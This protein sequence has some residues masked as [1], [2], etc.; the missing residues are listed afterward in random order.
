[1]RRDFRKSARRRARLAGALSGLLAVSCLSLGAPTARLPLEPASSEKIIVASFDFPESALLAELYAGILEADDYPVTRLINLGSRETV[2][3]ALLQG[4]VDLVP[5][6]LGT[7]LAFSSLGRSNPSSNTRDMT[8]KLTAVLQ[9]RGVSVA[10]PAEAQNRNGIVVTKET[11]ERY[12]LVAISDLREEASGFIFGGPP[13]CP[14]RPLCLPGLKAR[15]GLRFETF[16]PL[17][18]GGPA[19]VGALQTGEVDVGLLFTTDPDIVAHQFVLLEDDRELQPAENIV[20]ILRSEVLNRYG[21][22]LLKTIGKVTR[23]LTTSDLRT[24]NRGTE[25]EGRSPRIVAGEWLAQQGLV[26]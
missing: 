19:T 16:L 26:E 13:E 17:D 9:P 6:Y 8:K 20:P 10:K 15:Y 4:Q 1:M 18:A 14:E 11:A 3:P 21:S 24:L 12:G 25:L 2:D 23:R 7:A 5:E 22:G